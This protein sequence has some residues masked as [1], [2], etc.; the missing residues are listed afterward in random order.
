M[1]CKQNMV[2]CI[3]IR[4]LFKMKLPHQVLLEITDDNNANLRTFKVF[5]SSF[6]LTYI[7][8]FRLFVALKH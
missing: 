6:S 2:H 4:T 5:L 3:S 1:L 7:I 8:C